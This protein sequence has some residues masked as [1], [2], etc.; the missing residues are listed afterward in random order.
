MQSEF[1]KLGVQILIIGND[2]H[3]YG[4]TFV[5][6]GKVSAQHDHRIAMCFGILGM[7]TLAGIEIDE[8][9]A[10]AK[11]YPSFW[12]DLERCKQV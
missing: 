11:S 12:E 5:S 10:V 8:A 6:G 3:I 9:E 2:M 1:G 7:N 4:K